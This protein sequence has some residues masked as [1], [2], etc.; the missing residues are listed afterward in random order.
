MMNDRRESINQFCR[1]VLDGENKQ[2]CDIINEYDFSSLDIAAMNFTNETFEDSFKTVCQELFKLR[3]PHSAYII[4]ILAYA[5]K[6]NEYHLMYC[7]W[8][9]T[10][11]LTNTLVE[12]L[13][14][15]GFAPYTI[16][17]CTL[18]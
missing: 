4:A 10:D 9:R 18:L 15:N 2:I 14:V 7:S 16:N 3:R 17:R 12:V 1:T 6:L 13:M 5:L 8:Y 11:I